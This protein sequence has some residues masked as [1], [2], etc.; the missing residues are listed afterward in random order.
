MS[1]IHGAARTNY[2]RVKDL[3]AF[4]A[5]AH[6]HG[7]IV[8]QPEDTDLWAVYSA[9]GRC[10]PRGYADSSASDGRRVFDIV[11]ELAGHVALGQT[12]VWMQTRLTPLRIIVG[13]AGAFRVSEDGCERFKMS[14]NDIYW[15]AEE[16]WGA[17][18]NRCSG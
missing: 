1:D 4:L 17:A 9:D 11:D 10:W 16:V 13:E 3:V 12:V 14:L 18:P 5:W 2:F 7:L 8:R 6:T 15:Y